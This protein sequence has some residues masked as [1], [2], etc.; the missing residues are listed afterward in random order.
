MKIASLCSTIV[1]IIGLSFNSTLKAQPMINYEVYD[2]LFL[3]GCTYHQNQKCIFINILGITGGSGSYTIVGNSTVK[4]SKTS[5]G[6]NEGL[7]IYVPYDAIENNINFTI[8]DSQGGVSTTI[9]SGVK[10][11]LYY[12]ANIARLE[13]CL[14]PDKCTIPNIELLEGDRVYAD[15]Y[16]T[17]GEISYDGT[18]PDRNTSFI[19]GTS[20]TLKAGFSSV[21]FSNFEAKI[22]VNCN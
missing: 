4:V 15:T 10:N 12:A 21:D 14:A 8:T 2:N 3:W 5:V 6:E 9:N 20:I 17:Q 22:E 19:A 16:K 7:E 1:L 11:F 18:L 13:E